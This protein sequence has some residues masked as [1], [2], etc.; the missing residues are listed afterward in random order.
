MKYARFVV[1]GAVVL[2]DLSAVACEAE[3]AWSSL[4]SPDGTFRIEFSV[5]D[6]GKALYR[7]RR[8]EDEVILPSGLGF[9]EAGGEDWTGGYVIRGHP[10]YGAL[11]SDRHESGSLDL[12]SRCR[13]GGGSRT[14]LRSRFQL[15][16]KTIEHRVLCF[17]LLHHQ[18]LLIS[19]PG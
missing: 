14:S 6:K 9:V 16:R 13:Q 4:S 18:Q 10:F 19:T 8:G 7:V 2:L 12:A 3:D 15:E 17:D 1:I 5:G 11:G